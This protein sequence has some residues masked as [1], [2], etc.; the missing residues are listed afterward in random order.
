MSVEPSPLYG[1]LGDLRLDAVY[2]YY[3]GPALF[4]SRD[5]LNRAY[6]SVAVEKETFLTVPISED[7]LVSV[8]TGVVSLRSAF[9]EPEAAVSFVVR[10]DSVEAIQSAEISSDWFPDE[11]EYLAEAA[12]TAEEY[13]D[14]KLVQWADRQQRPLTALRLSPTTALRRTEFPLRHAGH[15]MQELQKLTDVI[16]VEELARGSHSQNALNDS[17]LALI[18]V[19]ASSVVFIVAPLL[20]D[21]LIYTPTEIMQRLARLFTAASEGDDSFG[22]EIQALRSRRT[23]AHVRDF[24][25]SVADSEADL[26]FASAYP[27]GCLVSAEVGL[28]DIQGCINYLRSRT[29]LPIVTL[30]G[31]GHLVGVNLPRSTFVIV[32]ARPTG[33]R[34]KPRQI[35]GVIDPSLRQT[36]DGSRVGESVT[37]RYRVLE[38]REIAEFTDDA[39]LPTYRLVELTEAVEST[40]PLLI[41]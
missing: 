36:I 7:R 17:E 30:N 22:R 3:D 18:Q 40:V 21:R 8:R 39:D 20:G 32:E 1:P 9:A 2:E 13:S 10:P 24:F 27:S 16:N 41:S 4:A 29:N 23:V 26:A 12:H 28:S 34:K 31:T 38:E 25:V 11:G 5:N 19:A 37:Y 14:E 6:L 15:I 33:T 35:R